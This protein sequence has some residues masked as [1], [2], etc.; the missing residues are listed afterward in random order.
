MPRA[1]SSGRSP[2]ALASLMPDSDT[3][4]RLAAMA[5]PTMPMQVGQQQAD[6]DDEQGG[7]ERRDHVESPALAARDDRFECAPVPLRPGDG[8]AE[9]DGEQAAQ[10]KHEAQDLGVGAREGDE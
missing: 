10:A 9:D 3:P 1:K 2:R 7:Q 5:P 4:A 6:G 8:G